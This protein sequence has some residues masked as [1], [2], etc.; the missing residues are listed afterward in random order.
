MFNKL[1]QKIKA[2]F[3]NRKK[4][5]L[6]S[7]MSVVSTRGNVAEENNV[8]EFKPILIKGSLMSCKNCDKPL[9]DDGSVKSSISDNGKYYY[10]RCSCGLVNKISENQSSIPNVTEIK[11]AYN[12]FKKNGVNFHS[13]SLTKEGDKELL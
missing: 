9:N 3:E 13:Y 5:K 10:V 2:S 7:K 12:L 8:V 4:K 11:T 1:L 6:K